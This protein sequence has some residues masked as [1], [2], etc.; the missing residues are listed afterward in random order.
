MDISYE[1]ICQVLKGFNVKPLSDKDFWRVVKRERIVVKEIPLIVDGY[2][3]KKRGRHYIIINSRLRGTKWLHTA[4]H[5]LMHFYLDVPFAN[6]E[7]TLYR[8]SKK[9][10][11]KPLRRE[12]TAD[13]FALMAILPFPELEKLSAEDLEDQTALASLVVARL[14]VLADLGK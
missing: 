4:F 2:Y 8:R 14:Q 13:A 7:A 1:R 6:E 5:E 10:T 12:E 9:K 11:K 3:Q